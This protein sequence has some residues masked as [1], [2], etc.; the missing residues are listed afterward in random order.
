MTVTGSPRI[1][2]T[3]VRNKASTLLVPAEENGPQF[4]FVT[5]STLPV[6]VFWQNSGNL[7]EKFICSQAYTG[8]D[9]G[10]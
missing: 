1:K 5:T 7:I 3:T 2:N 10:V 6:Q 9:E 4:Y 8:D